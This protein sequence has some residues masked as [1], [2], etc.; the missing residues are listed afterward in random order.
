MG[1]A[2]VVAIVVEVEGAVDIE[3]VDVE[4]VGAGADDVTMAD[5]EGGGRGLEGGDVNIPIKPPFLPL[6]HSTPLGV[7]KTT[8]AQMLNE[9]VEFCPK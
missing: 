3:A 8:A 5:D 2:V 7:T 1:Y 9:A 6:G 4:A